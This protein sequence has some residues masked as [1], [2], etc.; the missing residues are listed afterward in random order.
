M[1]KCMPSSHSQQI[2]DLYKLN[3]HYAYNYHYWCSTSC[4]QCATCHSWASLSLI[5]RH[6]QESHHRN[7]CWQDRDATSPY[8]QSNWC[9]S[10][11]RLCHGHQFVNEEISFP[12]RYHVNQ[13]VD[14]FYDRQCRLQYPLSSSLGHA[15]ERSTL[16]QFLKPSCL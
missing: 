12:I 6:R 11:V 10:L 4:A 16:G 9:I 13:F 5:Q 15:T 8:L 14:R 3:H 7:S 2:I 1:L